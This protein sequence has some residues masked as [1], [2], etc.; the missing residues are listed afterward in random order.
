M[1]ILAIET[2]SS[3]QKFGCAQAA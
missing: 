3:L 2:A 1:E